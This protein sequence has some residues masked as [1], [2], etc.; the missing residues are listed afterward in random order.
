MTAGRGQTFQYKDTQEP[1][2][3]S[4]TISASATE[5]EGPGLAGILATKRSQLLLTNTLTT[6]LSSLFFVVIMLFTLH[7]VGCQCLH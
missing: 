1:A 6:L 5:L 4:F 7:M 2:N 3:V